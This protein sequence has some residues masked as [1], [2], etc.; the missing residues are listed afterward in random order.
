M[1]KSEFCFPQGYSKSKANL[2]VTFLR[3]SSDS[4]NH[5]F[6]PLFHFISL[7]PTKTS[8]GKE[9]HS[10]LEQNLNV[11]GWFS[12]PFFIFYFYNK[13]IQRKLIHAHFYNTQLRV[14]NK[15]TTLLELFLIKSTFHP[16]FTGSHCGPVWTEVVLPCIPLG[17]KPGSFVCVP[18][19]HLLRQ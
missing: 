10:Q 9:R 3:R 7:C 15:W 13:E 19:L 14:N 18:S 17:A 12:F 4:K 11:T 1:F 5:C 16:G 2:R 8:N 6:P